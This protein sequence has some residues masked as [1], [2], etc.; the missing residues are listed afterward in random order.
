M[1]TNKLAIN[2]QNFA[3]SSTSAHVCFYNT[4]NDLQS[5]NVYMRER[6]KG[7]PHPTSSE[8]WTRRSLKVWTRDQ[9]WKK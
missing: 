4:T 1:N 6:E 5:K 3:P 8:R 9:R 7:L 2:W